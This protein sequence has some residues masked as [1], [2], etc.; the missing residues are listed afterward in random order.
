MHLLPRDDK[1][2]DLLTNQARIAVRA[3]SLLAG[4]L[5]DDVA[6]QIRD[7]EREGDQA[8]RQITRRL[9]KTFITPIDPEDIHQIASGI[10]EILDHVEAAAFR[11]EASG[12]DRP[13]ERMAEIA[14]MLNGCVE[15]TLQAM[16]ILERDGVGKPDEL[17]RQCDEINRIESE[18]EDR[19]RAAVRELYAA[20]RDPIVLIKLKD[21]YELL[22]T[23]ADCC[24]DVADTLEGIAV[25]NS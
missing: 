9:H 25:K 8:L 7:L 18:I 3:A 12:L 16:Q 11:I 22:E 15:A 23:A 14:R 21:I 5:G 19:V 2:Y 1:F 10:D 17:T 20:E 6:Q 4:G 13:P 24:E